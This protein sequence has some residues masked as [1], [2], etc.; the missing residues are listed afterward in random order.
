M[1]ASKKAIKEGAITPSFDAF[2]SDGFNASVRFS[3]PIL[4]A[5][6]GGKTSAWKKDLPYNIATGLLLMSFLSIFCLIIEEPLLLAFS[7]ASLVVFTALVTLE[8]FDKANIKY[9][10]CGVIALLL[11]A[12]AVIW[13]SKLG[14]GL[15]CLMNEFYDIA[16]ESQAYLYKR[17]SNGDDASD[18]DTWIAVAWVASLLGML[19]ALLPAAFRRSAS[20]ALTT[21]MMLVLAYYGV[22]PSWISIGWML[23]ALILTLSKG[24][25]LASLPLILAVVL[26][27]GAIVA[28]D[29]GEFMGISRMNENIRDRIAFHSAQIEKEEQT[30][31]EE[32]DLEELKEQDLKESETEDSFEHASYVVFA[33]IGLIVAAIAAAAYLLIKR[34]R[35]RRAAVRHG[36]DSKDPRES[37]IAMFPYSVRWLK[38]S[39]M[40][41]R[42][43]PFS[44]MTRDVKRLYSED[45]AKQFREMYS[46]WREAAYSDHEISDIDRKDMYRFMQNTENVA[47]AN[48]NKIQKLSVILKYAL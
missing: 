40:E 39:G 35:K 38:A 37:V 41:T 29:P 22:V 33:V 11:I 28:V 20:L 19:L 18:A 44:M 42:N 9:A 15:A 31:E 4:K 13:H 34:F 27:F 10:A 26:L 30:T 1:K 23:L 47:S 12:S 36:I 14:D 8:S 6:D 5:Y 16:E 17:F 21:L 2:A 7:A 46:L 24:N 45:Y 3:E 32:V 25:V 48:W 43:R